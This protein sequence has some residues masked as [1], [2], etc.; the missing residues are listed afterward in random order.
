MSAPIR[1]HSVQPDGRVL[2]LVGKSDA[3]REVEM[4]RTERLRLIAGLADSL[5]REETTDDRHRN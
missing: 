2:V 1:L 4:T 5:Y 3:L